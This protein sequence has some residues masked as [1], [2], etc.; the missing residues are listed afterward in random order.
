M[1]RKRTD[2]QSEETSLLKKERLEESPFLMLPVQLW[3]IYI[4]PQTKSVK[5]RVSFSESCY[6][7]NTLAHTRPN[8]SQRK[9]IR[10]E[11]KEG[12]LDAIELVQ[13]WNR[14]FQIELNLEWICHAVSETTITLDGEIIQ[15]PDNFWKIIHTLYL[16]YCENVT[17]VSALGN[18]KNLNR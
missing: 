14:V 7:F 8:L 13:H 6:W 12:L 18:V 2:F 1:K 5:D 9:I 4:L 3:A 17:D 11:K 10:L 16:S 15:I